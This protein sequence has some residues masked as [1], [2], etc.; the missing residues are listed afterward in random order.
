M[1]HTIS[2]FI[3]E[4]EE[5]EKKATPAKWEKMPSGY[6]KP[7]PSPYY[8]K[9]E[10]IGTTFGDALTNDDA[11][12]IAQSRNALPKLLQVLKVLS[13][14]LEHISTHASMSRQVADKAL[15]EAARILE[16]K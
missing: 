8:H 1:N 3:S 9:G 10:L 14:G 16:G 13:G 4:L 6:V 12:F 15:T 5:L 2:K 11:K 7:G